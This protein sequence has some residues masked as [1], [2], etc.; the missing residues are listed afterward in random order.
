MLYTSYVSI[1]VLFLSITLG[2][3]LFVKTELYFKKYKRILV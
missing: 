2:K 1:G 3:L